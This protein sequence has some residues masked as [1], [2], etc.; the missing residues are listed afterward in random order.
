M[1]IV[2]NDPVN[3]S[4]DSQPEAAFGEVD[5]IEDIMVVE[6]SPETFRSG[7]LL[8]RETVGDDWAVY[9]DAGTNGRNLVRGVLAHTFDYEGSPADVRVHIIVSG[10]VRKEKLY[11]FNGDP[12][13]NLETDQLQQA[14][15]I[16]KPSTQ[17]AEIDNPQP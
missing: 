2:S 3:T 4:I 14:S 16:A 17:L 9:D 12:V 7:L 5:M 13:T 6:S 10:N 8:A 15:I 11:V 1:P